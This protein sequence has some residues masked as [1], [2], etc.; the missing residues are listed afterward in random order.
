M[1]EWV[2]FTDALRAWA[3][4]ATMGELLAAVS[5]LTGEFNERGL[6]VTFKTEKVER[7]ELTR[8]PAGSPE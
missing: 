2:A 6:R 3:A 7:A 1:S 5:V 4:R 8:P